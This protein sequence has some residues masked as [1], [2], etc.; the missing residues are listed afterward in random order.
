MR[1]NKKGDSGLW[2]IAFL[3]IVIIFIFFILP[4]HNNNYEGYEGKL[5]SIQKVDYKKEI[6]QF[7]NLS[8]DNG[9]Y[10]ILVLDNQKIINNKTKTDLTYNMEYR[11]EGS[12]FY[13]ISLKEILPPTPPPTPQQWVY[14][15]LLITMPITIILLVIIFVRIY[16]LNHKTPKWIKKVEAFLFA[17]AI[18]PAL[19]LYW[20]RF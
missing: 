6:G 9:D 10:H 5:N 20:R 7:Y 8:F 15:L 1:I 3:P 19:G 17:L 13:L 14:F 2:I 16:C 12:I 11:T 4:I 18:I